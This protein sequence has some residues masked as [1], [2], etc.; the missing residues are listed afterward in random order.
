MPV[1]PIPNAIA[2]KHSAEL[3]DAIRQAIVAAGGHISFAKFMELALYAPGLGYYSA[4]S[5]KL[6]AMGDFSTAPEITPLFA[7]ALANQCQQIL[8]QMQLTDIIE[9][10][11]GSG[12]LAGDLL[13]ALEKA[14]CLPQHYFILEV[15]GDLRS[16]QA[17]HIQTHCPHLSARVQWLDHLPEHFSGMMI[18]NEVL[19]AMPTHVFQIQESGISEQCVSFANDT[20]QWHTTDP[21]SPEL[22]EKI[23]YLRDTF[24]LPVNFK[25]E[26]NLVAQAWIKSLGHCLDK[27]VILLIDYG[28]GEK[29]RY[30]PRRSTGSLMCYYQHHKHDNPFE[31]IGLQDITSHVDFTSIA[32]A[33]V[34]NSLSVAGY[35]T[36]AAFLLSCGILDLAEQKQ[37]SEID[38]YQQ[39]QALK[40]LTLPSEMGETVKVMALSKQLDQPL[41]GFVM[42]DRRHDL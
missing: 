3:S 23:S 35:T 24:H 36:Q 26:I 15:S 42:G 30:Q 14:N 29:E 11:A 34:D 22:A 21:A 27:G 2:L 28:Y 1:L 6:G 4:G 25:S 12:K 5:H 33:A 39:S 38:S 17:E 9:F 10:G 40:L 18:A 37:L 41:V 32:Q 7:E 20:F 8:I 31:L 16:R 19:D 13:L